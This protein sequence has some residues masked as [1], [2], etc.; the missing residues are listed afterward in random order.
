MHDNPTIAGGSEKGSRCLAV[1][2]P[3]TI[4]NRSLLD[5]LPEVCC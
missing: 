2:V 3:W 4:K 1:F 5:K